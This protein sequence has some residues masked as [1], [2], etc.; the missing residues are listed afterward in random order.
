MEYRYQAVR[1]VLAGSPITKVA[2]QYE[3]SRQS[4]HTWR[5]RF[6]ADGKPGS[7]DRSRR[8]RCSPSRL[9]PAVESLICELRQQHPRWGARRIVH[10]ISTQ[11]LLEAVPSRATVH[12]VLVRNGLV[13]AEEQQHPRKYRR[14]L[15]EAPMHLWQLDLVGG[16]PLADGREC[17]MVTGIDY[18]SRFVVI[19]AV[20]AVPSGRAV[21]A[22]FT[23]AMHRYGVPFEVLS[24]NGKQFTGRHHRPQP[25]EVMFQK[26]DRSSTSSANG[27]IIVNK[28]RIKLGQRHAGKLVTVVIENTHYRVLH[29]GEEVAV[30][31]RKDTTPITRLH[32]RGKG[33]Q[34]S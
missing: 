27:R 6:E 2:A 21:C 16:L 11:R 8:P 25:V 32:V 20:V 33:A 14:R 29:D 15:R 19:A 4:L 1:E 18:H 26:V 13:A 34:P 31:T 30:R 5:S 12:R 24:D 9:L 22:A 10:D 23:A 3:T 7:A 28:Q 17:K